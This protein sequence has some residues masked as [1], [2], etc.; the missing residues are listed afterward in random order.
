MT[1]KR[2]KRLRDASIEARGENMRWV[3]RVLNE[4]SSGLE[5]LSPAVTE[6]MHI[7]P[8]SGEATNFSVW[9]IF[10]TREAR[11]DSAGIKAFDEARRLVLSALEASS[12]PAK[13]LETFKF[14]STSREEIEEAG[15]HFAF[16]R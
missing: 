1:S 5:A 16:F 14:Y 2:T 8:F 10:A 3:E 12:Y 7:G 4:C 11:E 9:L 6:T 13:A 15:G